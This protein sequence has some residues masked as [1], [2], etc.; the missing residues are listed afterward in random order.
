MCWRS[1]GWQARCWSGTFLLPRGE[2]GCTR[3]RVASLPPSLVVPQDAR[4]PCPNAWSSACRGARACRGVRGACAVPHPHTGGSCSA[5]RHRC[6]PPTFGSPCVPA[7][8][9]ARQPRR[10][11]RRQQPAQQRRRGPQRSGGGGRAWS[12]WNMMTR[13]SN[14][15]VLRRQRRRQPRQQRRRLCLWTALHQQQQEAGLRR[16]WA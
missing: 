14:S 8:L 12:G 9:A 15:A 3:G 10:Q 5:L 7:G 11:R 6:E 13:I 16:G 4:L 2:W 1:S